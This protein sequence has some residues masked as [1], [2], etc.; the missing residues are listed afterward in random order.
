MTASME[1][2]TLEYIRHWSLM[3][4]YLSEELNTLV[5]FIL[6]GNLEEN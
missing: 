1:L 5:T 4:Q 2:E 6:L 3:M